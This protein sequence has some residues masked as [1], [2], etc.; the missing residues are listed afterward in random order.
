MQYAQLKKKAQQGFTLIELMIVVAI[1]G[2]LAAVAIPQYQDYVTR[3]KLVKVNVAVESIKTAIGVFAQENAGLATIPASTFGTAST[4][5]SI[6]LT[7]SP[8]ATAEVSAINITAGTGAVVV[9][10]QGIGAPYNGSTVTF[11]PT[12]GATSLAW[13]QTCSVAGNANLAKVFGCP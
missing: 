8:V 12:P 9:T 1:I 4:W 7:G 2:I 5:T 13:S 11:L 10:M 3:A 6:G